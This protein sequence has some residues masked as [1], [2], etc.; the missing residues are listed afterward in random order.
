MTAATAAATG[1]FSFIALRFLFGVGEAGAF[2]GVTRAMQ[3]WYPRSERGFVQGLT[4]SAT[5]LGA[6][7]SPPSAV[8]IV[9]T[10]CRR[11]A[12]YVSGASGLLSSS[13]RYCS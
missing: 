5:R 9:T 7:R 4:H 11:S 8:L 1:A 6:A 2:P 12:F 3:L 13:W 10:L